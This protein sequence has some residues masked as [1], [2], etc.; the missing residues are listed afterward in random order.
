MGAPRR[1]TALVSG[2]STLNDAAAIALFAI[3]IDAL[4][5]RP[6]WD[7]GNV[8][9]T[10]LRDFI[11]GIAVGFIAAQ[12]TSSLL[13][14]LFNIPL[15]E[16]TVTVALAYVTYIMGDVLVDVSGVVAVVVAAMTFAVEGRSRLS[17]GTWEKL[18]Q[19]WQQ[20]DFWAN[21]LI[22]V[23]A[24]MLATRILPSAGLSDLLYLGVLVL[25]A[26]AARAGVLYGLLP[27]L[28]T[29]RATAPIGG[30]YKLVL[31]WGGLRGAIT[32]TLAVSVSQHEMIP[33]DDRHFVSVLATA[34][35]LFT[36]FVQGPTLKPLLRLLRLD[37]LTPNELAVRD[38]VIALSKAQ[39]RNDIE[40][41]TRDYGFDP[42][43]AQP[44]Y[45]ELIKSSD[46]DKAE[47][48]EGAQ[49][50]DGQPQPGPLAAA[51]MSEEAGVAV[52][53]IAPHQP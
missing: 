46:A 17:P 2:E 20:L 24:A 26:F 10:L 16:I 11:G 31:L 8:M 42:E 35:V 49:A 34:Y 27:V 45:E 48:P 28:S 47:R 4:V 23:L 50:D 13:R 43:L 53:L 14:H 29:L 9:V 44:L 37:Q 38:G 25:A 40:V 1:L 3:L 19:T 22:F 6:D 39:V 7:L 12:I 52:G 41:V 32:L 5:D 18:L 33:E 51:Q 36:L 21:S 15:A 30:R